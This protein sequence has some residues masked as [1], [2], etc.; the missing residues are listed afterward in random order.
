MRLSL[1]YAK[2]VVCNS[3]RMNTIPFSEP[4]WLDRLQ[5]AVRKHGYGEI[6]DVLDPDERARLRLS[7][8]S[9]RKRI[10]EDIGEEKMEA[11]EERGDREIRLSLAYDDTFIELLFRRELIAVVDALLSPTAVLRFQNVEI[12]PPGDSSPVPPKNLAFHRNTPRCFPGHLLSL[13]LLYALTETS[14]FLVPGTHQSNETPTEAALEDSGMSWSV[15]PGSLFVLDSTLWH[16]GERNDGDQTWYSIESQFTPSFVKPHF[17]YPRVLGSEK[18]EALPERAQA[19]LGWH[20]RIPT[21]LH[22][23]YVD[24]EERLYRPNQG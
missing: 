2:R 14:F 19:M 12:K 3:G 17:D 16:R 6:T 10:I 7:C 15:K 1:F 5:I 24:P 22:E 8:D 23:F 11:A 21:S 20:T 13:D 18:I 4:D 9:V